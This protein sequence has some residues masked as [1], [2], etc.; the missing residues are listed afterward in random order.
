MPPP[1][2]WVDK[3]NYQIAVH[4]DPVV[5][6]TFL[7]NPTGGKNFPRGI[8]VGLPDLISYCFDADSCQ[9]RFAWTGDT[10]R[11]AEVFAPI[12]E[13]AAPIVE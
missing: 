5:M 7:P 12:R 13:A 11:G 4:D 1:I 10:A 3:N 8:A 9:L 6:R 2:G